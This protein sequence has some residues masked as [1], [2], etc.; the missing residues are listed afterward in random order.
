MRLFAVFSKKKSEVPAPAGLP[1]SEEQFRDLI[2]GVEDKE[3]RARVPDLSGKKILELAP[4]QKSASVFLREKGA[5]V[6][7]R[8]G[9]TK[10]KEILDR[11]PSSSPETFILSHWESLPF[12]DSCFDFILVR[13]AFLKVSLGRVL[14]EVGRVLDTKGS[15]L[16]SDFHPFSQM[17][18]REHLKNP[19]GEEGMGPGLERYAKWFREAGFRFEWVREIFFEGIMKKSFGTSEAHQQ[20]F[21]GLRRTPF[22]IL[23][24]LKKE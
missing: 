23:F 8:L 17:V 15:V 13:S 3:L 19:V 7:V 12:L 1:I 21:D 10:E 24:S 11:D 18:Q 5:G 14:R 20:A 6:V 16:L 2:H 9:G 22:L 4:R